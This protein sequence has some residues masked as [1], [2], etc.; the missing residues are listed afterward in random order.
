LIR[1]HLRQKISQWRNRI[2]V[3]GISALLY[4]K[5]RARK[6]HSEI[7]DR[8]PAVGHDPPGKQGYPYRLVTPS[9]A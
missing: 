7:G 8:D 3:I 6:D 5:A 1:V 2:D 4:Y 9:R